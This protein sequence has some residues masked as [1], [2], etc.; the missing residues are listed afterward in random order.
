[1]WTHFLLHLYSKLR[2][3]RAQESVPRVQNWFLPSKA[4]EG[5]ISLQDGGRPGREVRALGLQVRRQTLH[6]A[7]TPAQL[8]AQVE[9]GVQIDRV[10]R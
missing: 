1:M 2:E 6:S 3:V 4:G 10:A 5:L 7:Q 8:W 9:K